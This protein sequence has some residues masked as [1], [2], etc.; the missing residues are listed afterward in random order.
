LIVFEQQPGV[1]VRKEIF[2]LRGLLASSKV[3]H[4]GASIAPE[5]AAQLRALIDWNLPGADLR[6]PIPVV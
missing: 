6:R 3:R 2:R 5:T 4:P 1:A